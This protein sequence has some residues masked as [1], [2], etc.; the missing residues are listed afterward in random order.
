MNLIETYERVAS[1]QPD[2]P[3]IVIGDQVVTYAELIE[4]V[5]RVA[6][7]LQAL[8][9]RRGDRV[10]IYAENRPEY[11]A[12]HLAVARLGAITATINAGFRRGE[13][14]YVL[15]NARPRCVVVEPEL[16]PVLEEAVAA[17]GHAPETTVELA[18][19]PDRSL[20]DLPDTEPVL[21]NA[22]ME[23]RAGVLIS[24][25]SG[26]S[27]RPKPVFHSHAGQAFLAR[28]HAAG[29]HLAPTDRV[30]VSLPMAWLY[31]LTTT[32][33]AALAGG[34]TV[35]LQRHF[36]PVRALDDFERHGITVFAG[37]T[38]MYV[39][40]LDAFRQ[41]GTPLRRNEL[42]LCVTGGEPINDAA[43]AEFRRIFGVPIHD[44]YATSEC[45]PLLTYDPL[46]EPE[47]RPGSCGRL[48]PG[49]EARLVDPQGREVPVGEPGE[50][51]VRSPGQMLGYYGEPE[52]TEAVVS[53][54]WF[55]T[56]DLARRDEDGYF[57]LVGRASEL[58]IRGGANVSPLEVESVLA[59]HP[60]VAECA[61][62]GFPDS[63]YGQRVVAFVVAASEQPPD[64]AELRAHCE[65]QL[66]PYKVPELFEPVPELPRGPTGKVVKKALAERWQP[67][68]ATG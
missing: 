63:A 60:A 58:I 50:L 11:L 49:A 4:Q 22:D 56:G 67:P 57:Y 18:D 48:L 39:K 25:T 34:A 45:L 65:R 14:E 6:G 42:R 52:M 61:V 36:N 17:C 8:G 55:R 31:G 68:T 66:A 35:V 30:L 7:G 16:R 54:G 21:E 24:Y 19:T 43:F 51:L 3:A 26:T 10:A 64:A 37:V 29:W 20:G 13:I 5:G 47:P 15:G 2:H 23:E 62:V 53:D 38:T 59:S 27:A 28:T 32:A 46:E 41:R 1:T 33:Q 9:V 12:V 40:L 44:V